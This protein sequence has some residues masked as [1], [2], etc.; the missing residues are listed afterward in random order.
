[1]SF[2][3]GSTSPGM[4]PRGA[5]RQFGKEEDGQLFNKYVVVR[6]LSFLRPYRRQ[7]AAAFGLMLA[8][9]AL[10]LLTPYLIKVAI[11]THIAQGDEAGLTRIALLTAAAFSGLYAATVGQRYLLSWV[12]QRVLANMRQQLFQHLQMLSLGYHD[13]HIIGV[14]VSRVINDV[15]VINELL[16][17]G[18]ISL[19]GDL[20]VL[21]G[22]IVVMLTMNVR[23]ALTTFTVLPLMMLATYFFSRRAKIAFRQTR[24]SIAAVVADL[25]E[26][27][28][29]MRVIQAFA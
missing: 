12:G 16:S 18:L 19:I 17:Q 14:T 5:L 3:I 20:L 25:A 10:T 27:I 26:G 1:M 8:A 9:S 24:S 4:G 2:S 29:G 28:A 21:G 6:M 7:M 23:L 15:A 13:T 22:I 11:D